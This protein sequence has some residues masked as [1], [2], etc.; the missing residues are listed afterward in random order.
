M[1][2]TEGNDSAWFL[3]FVFWKEAWEGSMPML[4]EVRGS[5]SSV[6]RAPLSPARCYFV[7]A[8]L[9]NGGHGKRIIKEA[10]HISGYILQ[11]DTW[12]SAWMGSPVGLTARVGKIQANSDFE[13]SYLRHTCGHQSRHWS[14]RLG[15]L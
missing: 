2:R 10:R 3:S 7:V 1:Y 6:A 15:I 9:N 4:E 5:Q 13:N 12:N 8:H 11:E 14:P